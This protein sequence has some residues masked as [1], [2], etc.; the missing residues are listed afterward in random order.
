MGKKERKGKKE[1]VGKETVDDDHA[2]KAITTKNGGEKME[3]SFVLPL[4]F[5]SPLPFFLPSL[6][7]FFRPPALLIGRIRPRLPTR[8]AV[9]GQDRHHTT[10]QPPCLCE[11]SSYLS[12]LHASLLKWKFACFLTYKLSKTTA[13]SGQ[14]TG[15]G[16]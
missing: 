4:F 14:I 7:L 11:C 6:F 5:L 10:T 13:P 1:S 8:G 3:T 2:K 16:D 15:P 9:I 12:I